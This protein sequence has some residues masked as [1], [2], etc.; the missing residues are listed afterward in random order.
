MTTTL[1][2]AIAVT[3]ISVIL[4]FSYIQESFSKE[5]AH[6]AASTARP[7]P[8]ATAS[9]KPIFLLQV[10]SFRA[11]NQAH[12][13]SEKL[14]AKGLPS[15]VTVL[16]DKAHTPWYIVVSGSYPTKEAAM[17]A[18]ESYSRQTGGDYYIKPF[19]DAKLQKRTVLLKPTAPTKEQP[20]V[21]LE[22]NN[23]KSKTTQ[24]ASNSEKPSHS[25]VDNAQFGQ[26]PSATKDQ[27][28]YLVQVGSFRAPEN[29][30]HMRSKLM[31]AR[32]NSGISILYDKE[33]RPWYIV[34]AGV[35]GSAKAARAVGARYA[36]KLGADF[37]IKP[38]KAQVLEQRWHIAFNGAGEI[39]PPQVPPSSATVK[40]EPL[41]IKT[42]KALP[43]HAAAEGNAN[44]NVNEFLS[45][46][47]GTKG[48][49]K[50]D[51]LTKWNCA[52]TVN[53]KNEVTS[54]RLALV[55]NIIN[56][57]NSHL[58]TEPTD[59]FAV[60]MSPHSTNVHIF[61]MKQ[62]RGN[63]DTG[64]VKK[65]YGEDGVTINKANII[66]YTDAISENTLLRLMAEAL[67]LHGIPKE[68][69]NSANEG[70]TG[71]KILS[72]IKMLYTPGLTPGM[73]EQEARR[74]LPTGNAQQGQ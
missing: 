72:A 63:E 32:W 45:L 51:M 15:V 40:P 42:K 29:A 12:D 22:K 19:D 61:F 47:L 65:Y 25:T 34:V 11:E 62:M 52:V 54:E 2:R 48:A 67:G 70:L 55:R 35:E 44:I 26:T 13:A 41:H 24:H 7:E 3:V 66:V 5:I 37:I 36:R 20:A 1:L 64:Y 16:Y 6:Q 30:E 17:K 69:P 56:S 14:K 58:P 57:I 68:M 50:S 74:A 21:R 73:N 39:A 49:Y 23:A 60:R 28:K 38:I 53:V 10:A 43:P 9:G 59:H 71:L 31:S 4:C 46:A 27:K 33:H 18:G 8:T